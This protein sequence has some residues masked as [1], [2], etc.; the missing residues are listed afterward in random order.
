MGYTAAELK[1]GDRLS[2][3]VA[4]RAIR[5]PQSLKDGVSSHGETR[6]CMERRVSIVPLRRDT[7]YRARCAHR[8]LSTPDLQKVHQRKVTKVKRSQTNPCQSKPNLTNPAQANRL[9]RGGDTASA[10]YNEVRRSSGHDRVNCRLG[11][12]TVD[13]LQLLQTALSLA[14]VLPA[15]SQY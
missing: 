13:A 9:W 11:T 5:E 14:S 10:R 7:T 2:E 6:I 1:H 8:A 4:D 15:A 12:R 3:I